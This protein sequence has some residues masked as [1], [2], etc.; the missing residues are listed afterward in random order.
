MP[1]IGAGTWQYND[2]VAYESVC[3]AFEAGYTFVDTALG[4]GNQGGVGRAIKDCWKGS[5]DELFVMTKIPGG[6][7]GIGSAGGSRAEFEGAGIELRR[8]RDDALSGR[9]ARISR[10]KLERTKAGGMD[11]AREH[12]LPWTVAFDWD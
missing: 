12:I 7:I 3:K 5:R 11:G 10:Q 9:L 4:Y 6:L 1:L 8:S 2:T